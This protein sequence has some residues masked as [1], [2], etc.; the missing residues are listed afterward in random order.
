L[1]LFGLP[2]TGS[3]LLD[4]E[5]V[6]MNG[7]GSSGHGNAITWIVHLAVIAGVLLPVGIWAWL[8]LMDHRDAMD[9][10]STHESQGDGAFSAMEYE[11]AVTAYGRA[12]NVRDTREI[13]VK[14]AR[15]RIYLA[16]IR[17]DAINGRDIKEIDYERR[18][19][20]GQDPATTAT[21]LAVGGHLDRLQNRLDEAKKAYTQALEKDEDCVPAHLGMGLLAYGAGE[22]KTAGPEFERVLKALPEHAQSL[23]SLADIRL[24][25]G[26][27]DD[28]AALYKR[29]L[30]VRENA[31][32]HLG[33]GLAY[34]GNNKPK[35]AEQEY[36]K[37]IRL[38]PK[39]FDANAALGNLYLN[40]EVYTKAEKAFRAALGIMP[41]SSIATNLMRT[42]NIMSRYG[43]ALKV[44]GPYL[45][46][47]P[48]RP[49]MLIE[50][51]RAAA[52]VGLK[53]DAR[54]FFAAV[55]E[56]VDGLGKQIPA[57]VGDIMKKEA[58]KGLAGLAGGPDKRTR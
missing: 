39:D 42:L 47:P 3:Q 52:G 9:L 16:G 5:V 33:L 55:P 26:K 29:V 17:P 2:E 12:G 34:A 31:R 1:I 49:D 27:M 51:G 6:N 36:L 28:A 10:A 7:N 32:A 15:A 25:G 20:M 18:W 48:V 19:L 57:K 46:N 37:A 22:G 43:D 45:N 24:T 30:A 44:L 50:A 14:L 40:A 8:T 23:I 4:F 54:R 21:C 35:E 38:N 53:E 11:T 41:E 56:I 58:E 13:Q